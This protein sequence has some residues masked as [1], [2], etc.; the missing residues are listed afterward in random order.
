[1]DIDHPALIGPLMCELNLFH[2]DF[3]IQFL[4]TDVCE[5]HNLSKIVIAIT[6]F[7]NNQVTIS[8][9]CCHV[10]PVWFIIL[11]INND[12]LGLILTDSVIKNLLS[13]VSFH[14]Y[15]LS[16]IGGSVVSRVEKSLSPPAYMSELGPH[17][18]IV[19]K[20]LSGFWISDIY[21]CPIR[22]WSLYGISHISSI[23]TPYHLG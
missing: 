8:C 22:S 4:V 14:L 15:F 5:G 20:V 17:Q 3:F 21:L 10:D 18:V 11:L 19:Y 13:P 7:I 9:S 23:R 2:L 12:I 6:P 1:M 16:L